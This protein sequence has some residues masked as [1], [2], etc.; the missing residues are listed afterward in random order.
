MDV[1]LRDL[2]VK[3][4]LRAA[5]MAAVVIV[6]ILHQVTLRW[7]LLASKRWFLLFIDK[8][9]RDAFFRSTVIQ[10]LSV[11]SIPYMIG[12]LFGQKAEFISCFGFALAADHIVRRYRLQ[13]CSNRVAVTTG[14]WIPL[15]RA[16][17]DHQNVANA[18]LPVA[19]PI[20]RD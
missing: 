1:I 14:R 17:P 13:R 12:Y 9:K 16:V 18:D 11:C 3:L 10:I 4:R 7:G 5:A 20:S 8:M 2:P 15:P 19:A 6:C